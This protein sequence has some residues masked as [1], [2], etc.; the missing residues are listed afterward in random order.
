MRDHYYKDEEESTSSPYDD[1]ENSTFSIKNIQMG[2]FNDDASAL[3]G[4]VFDWGSV[5]GALRRMSSND[6]SRGVSTLTSA[7][8][9]TTEGEY[10]FIY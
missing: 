1:Q 10:S 7:Q 2:R 9:R 4:S 5:G 3:N 6:G 8:G